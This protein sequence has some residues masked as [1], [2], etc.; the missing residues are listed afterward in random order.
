MSDEIIGP[1]WIACNLCY[2]LQSHSDLCQLPTELRVCRVIW[3]ML[4]AVPS[5][6][7]KRHRISEVQIYE[8][9]VFRGIGGVR[10]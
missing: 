8:R 2:T 10:D 6:L 4:T 5:Q 1:S 9:L 7:S 3:H